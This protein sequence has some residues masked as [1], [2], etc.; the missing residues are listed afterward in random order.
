MS[1]FRSRICWMAC[2][3]W[4]FHSLFAYEFQCISTCFFGDDALTTDD[5]SATDLTAAAR[6]KG[7]R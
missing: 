1:E 7:R 5:T 6:V 3:L 2:A 4:V